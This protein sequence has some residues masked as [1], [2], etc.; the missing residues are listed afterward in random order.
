MGPCDDDRIHE[1]PMQVGP[2]KIQPSDILDRDQ[3]PDCWT[4]AAIAETL[5]YLRGA[6]GLELPAS[7]KKYLPI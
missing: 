5:T 4:D 1:L 2:E 3:D 7:W 6:Q